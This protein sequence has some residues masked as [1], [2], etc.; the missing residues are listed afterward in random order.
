MCQILNVALRVSI[1]VNRTHLKL[2]PYGIYIVA[3]NKY[4]HTKIAD[5]MNR[6]VRIEGN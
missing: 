3:H 6:E 4:T 2:L 5:N 1:S